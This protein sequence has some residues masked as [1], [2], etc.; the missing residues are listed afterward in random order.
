MEEMFSITDHD[1]SNYAE[2]L[3]FAS[4]IKHTPRSNDHYFIV[5]GPYKLNEHAGE[6][7][8]SWRVTIE[9]HIDG[10]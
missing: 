8:C 7:D 4:E 6:L 3:T 1:F 10:S 2:A 9:T 5:V